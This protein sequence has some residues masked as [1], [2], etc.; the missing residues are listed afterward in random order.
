MFVCRQQTQNRHSDLE[1]NKYFWAFFCR[2]IAEI[3]ALCVSVE[4]ASQQVSVGIWRFQKSPIGWAIKG[5]KAGLQSGTD[6]VHRNSSS[7][8]VQ[9]RPEPRLCLELE[10]HFVYAPGPFTAQTV[11]EGNQLVPGSL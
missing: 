7:S 5:P 10:K 2:L 4:V 6:C 1:E 9:A 3:A 8:Q 11:K